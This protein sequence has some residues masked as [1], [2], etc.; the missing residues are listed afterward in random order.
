MVELPQPEAGDSHF[1]YNTERYW[2]GC[3]II[4]RKNLPNLLKDD[5]QLCLWDMLNDRDEESDESNEW[6]VNR[7]GLTRVNITTF[8]RFLVMEKQPR[9]LIQTSRTPSLS[10]DINYTRVLSRAFKR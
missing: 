1:T 6:I 3:T 2:V 9:D 4:K 10:A 5:L 8:E 7:G